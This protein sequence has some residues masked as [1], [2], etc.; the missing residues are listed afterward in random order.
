VVRDFVLDLVLTEQVLVELTTAPGLSDEFWVT[1]IQVLEIK[2][3][4]GQ[5]WVAQTIRWMVRV[6]EKFARPPPEDESHPGVVQ[7]GDL[8]LVRSVC[9]SSVL[10]P[11]VIH[12]APG[13][14]RSASKAARR[15]LTALEYVPDSVLSLLKFLP[16]EEQISTMFDTLERLL[17]QQRE[18]L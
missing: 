6:A 17:Q 14:L 8:R 10:V 11:L 16:I 2:G 5:R 4:P 15:M 1:V 13:A 18:M 7:E 3:L 12:L 9:T